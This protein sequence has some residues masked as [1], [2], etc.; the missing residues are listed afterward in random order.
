[1]KSEVRVGRFIRVGDEE[2]LD[3]DIGRF[4]V[5]HSL[6][7]YFGYYDKR[8]VKRARRTRGKRLKILLESFRTC[9]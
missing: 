6:Y 5:R 4:C 9:A 3:C 2:A 1:M 8:R 7:S